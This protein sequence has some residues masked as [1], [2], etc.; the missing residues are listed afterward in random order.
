MKRSA[1]LVSM[2]LSLSLTAS[3]L[4]AFPGGSVQCSVDQI[5]KE[6]IQG[7]F[8]ATLK[9]WTIANLC[10]DDK[11]LNAC[12]EVVT[13]MLNQLI[14]AKGT[15]NLSAE[16]ESAMNENDVEKL[17]K[18]VFDS[19]KGM[20]PS[21]IIDFFL[22]DFKLTV[23]IER[24]PDFGP[25]MTIT[26]L[27]GV[28]SSLEKV[29]KESV[30]DDERGSL[31]FPDTSKDQIAARLSVLTGGLAVREDQV[32]F[33]TGMMNPFIS[34]KVGLSD[35][36]FLDQT[37]KKEVIVPMIV[38]SDQGEYQFVTVT[39]DSEGKVLS[40]VSQSMKEPLVKE[41]RRDLFNDGR[42]LFG[43]DLKVECQVLP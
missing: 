17:P 4:G 5:W 25:E 36:W 33:P 28:A 19:L 16:I 21:Q 22:S 40:S 39:L 32:L 31:L 2:G 37:F 7:K 9:S 29:L 12:R 35:S 11:D 6:K 41:I 27:V 3:A 14:E 38:K 18:I 42:V 20:T 34:I 23:N 43:S 30:W 13:E 15:D 8:E 10:R 1:V 26:G 24:N